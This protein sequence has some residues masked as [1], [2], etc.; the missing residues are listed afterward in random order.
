MSFSNI[1]QNEINE[2]NRLQ[3]EQFWDRKREK[4]ESGQLAEQAR[5]K[6]KQKALEN[7]RKPMTYYCT[8]PNPKCL[9]KLEQL[10]TN[11]YQ[12]PNCKET[13]MKYGS[14]VQS[15]N[16][17]EAISDFRELQKLIFS[18]DRLLDEARQIRKKLQFL[19]EWE[20]RD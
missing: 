3:T 6:Q 1:T 9:V 2:Q 18:R 11:E 12:C 8:N 7:A 13:F 15:S 19:E 4:E 17:I 20:H 10:S 14:F 16:G 5:D